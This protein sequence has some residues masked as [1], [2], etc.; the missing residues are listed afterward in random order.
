MVQS[1]VK[2]GISVMLKSDDFSDERRDS[3]V[4]QINNWLGDMIRNKQ[5][6]P[7]KREAPLDDSDPT[8]L[9]TGGAY[10]LGEQFL[11]ACLNDPEVHAVESLDRDLGELVTLT[12]RRHHQLK[13]NKKA[14]AYARSL[15]RDDSLCQLFATKLAVK[16]QGAINWLDAHDNE[17]PESATATWRVRL[18]TIP[19]YHAHAFLIQ[20]MKNGTDVAVGDSC[21]FVISAPDWLDKLPK[22]DFLTSRQFLLGFKDKKPIIGLRAP[23]V[24]DIKTRAKGATAMPDDKNKNRVPI[25]ESYLYD[26][27][28]TKDAL[29]GEGGGRPGMLGGPVGGENPK[30]R[31]FVY[32]FIP[33]P[34]VPEVDN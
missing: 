13:Y 12:G 10:E 31:M 32:Q 7:D 34:E 17:L 26:F 20:K 27:E 29:G 30:F 33:P 3:L 25:F 4:K 16:L 21:V 2:N 11:M 15:E 24:P 19:T 1:R 28:A 23:G 5:L 14:V 6:P 9:P 8:S 18:V 22:E